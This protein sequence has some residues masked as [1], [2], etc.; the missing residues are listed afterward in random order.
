MAR[1]MFPTP[2]SVNFSDLAELILVS[3][4]PLLSLYYDVSVE[5]ILWSAFKEAL[6]SIYI[7]IYL[8]MPFF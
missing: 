1:D 6:L 2:P 7:Y 4:S 5:E 3:L 8:Y